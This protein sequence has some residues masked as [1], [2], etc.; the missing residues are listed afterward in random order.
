MVT[1]IADRAQPSDGMPIF[2][3]YERIPFESYMDERLDADPAAHPLCPVTAC[4][5]DPLA[6]RGRVTCDQDAIEQAA[7]RY[8]RIWFL[9]ATADLWPDPVQAAALD[10]ALRQA[11]VTPVGAT[12]L[13][14]SEV[15]EEVRQ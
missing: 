5:V 15:T 3:P 12:H 9:S 13:R 6:L 14:G 2:Y 1:C 11:G 10:A 8:Q 4:C 7:S